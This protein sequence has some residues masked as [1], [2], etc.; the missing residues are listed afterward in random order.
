M[1]LVSLGYLG[2]LDSNVDESFWFLRVLS[3][4]SVEV[5][6]AEEEAREALNDATDGATDADVLAVLL[7]VCSSVLPHI[8]LFDEI[9]SFGARHLGFQMILGC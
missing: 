5:E 9:C 4:L 8:I 2:Y 7:T 1:F 6:D 3:V